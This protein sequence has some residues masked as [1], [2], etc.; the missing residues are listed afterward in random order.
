[1]GKIIYVHDKHIWD[2]GNTFGRHRKERPGRVVHLE[3]GADAKVTDI[4][5]DVTKAAGSDGIFLLVFNAHGNRGCIFIGEGIMPQRYK[6]FKVLK[7]YF[8][9]SR[10]KSLGIEI[11]SCYFAASSLVSQGENDTAGGSHTSANFSSWGAMPVHQLAVVDRLSRDGQGH[12]C[13]AKLADITGV[14][15]KG[16][17]TAQ[18]TDKLGRFEGKWICARPKGKITV[19]PSSVAPAAIQ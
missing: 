9:K 15:V 2:S 1:M 6:Y 17:Y 10:P 19:H 12:L 14:N 7:P 8:F 11:H 3:Y 4:L 13:A 16:S 18:L 5:S